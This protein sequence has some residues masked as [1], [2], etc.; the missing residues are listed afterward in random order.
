MSHRGAASF[1]F[2]LLALLSALSSPA[3]AKTI[4]VGIG[5]DFLKIQDAIDSS[6][7]G[8]IIYVQ[9]GTY[10]ESV[11]VTKRLILIGIGNPVVD[12]REN[13][14]AIRIASGGTL[15]QGF[16]ATN[17]SETGIEIASDD[18]IIIANLANRNDYSGI[19]LDGACNNTIVGNILSNNNVSGIELD[20]SYGNTIKGNL[21]RY[22]GDTGI[23]L[24]KSNGNVIADNTVT[25][26]DN[27]GIEL[28]ACKDNTIKGN[29]V[30]RNKDGICAEDKSHDNIIIINNIYN[31]YIDGIL[32]KNSDF[33]IFVGNRI[34]GNLKA[35][36]L[37]A[38]A[39]NLI[40]NNNISDN[41]DGVH[42]NYYC[43]DNS[44]YGNNL[45]N[46]TNYNAYDESGANQWYIGTTGNH[47]S[48]F[49]SRERGCIDADDNGACDATY[50]IPGG[51]SL[52]KYPL[53]S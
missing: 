43:R 5:A 16:H 21:E 25:D 18:N 12:A 33:N 53:L 24:E 38:S 28:K 19:G 15:L 46:N 1:G 52:D 29:I 36:F 6:E 14:S 48:D 2:I 30:M 4:N 51:S 13:D 45:V 10:Q 44:V 32:S 17:S 11:A 7:P 9:N 22:S 23:E 42:L 3:Y 35:V 41:Q 8:D 26:N 47:Y 49:D 34:S 50:K 37:E 20:Q 40:K 27:D 31:N 39:G